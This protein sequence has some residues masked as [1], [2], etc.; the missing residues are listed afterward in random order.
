MSIWIANIQI[1]IIVALTT[2]FLLT[3][4]S[5]RPN[6]LHIAEPVRT[7]IDIN[8]DWLFI[9]GDRHQELKPKTQWQSI[10]LP[11]T[12]NAKDGL[13]GG[14]DY[15]RGYGTYQKHFQ[16]DPNLKGKRV[17]LHFD[18]ASIAARVYINDEFVG[19]HKGSYGAFRFDITDSI[20]WQG[21]NSL[22]VEVNNEEDHNVAPLSAD[23][24]FFGGLYRQA[25][26]IV[27][28]QV[29]VDMLDYASPGV[30][31]SQNSVDKNKA[32][33]EVSSTIINESETAETV[34]LQAIIK[35]ADG[36]VVARTVRNTTIPAGEDYKFSELLIVSQPHLWH[37]RKDPYLYRTYLQVSAA[38]Q[39]LDRVEQPIGLRF[40]HVDP[41]QGFFLNGE[42]YPLHGVNR[43]ADFPGM[44]TAITQEQHDI[45]MK[46][47][48]DIGAT[49]IRLGHQQRD[50]YVYSLTDK[51][52]LVVWAE[53]P[54]IN[55]INDDLAFS[56]NI[57]QQALELIKQNY[58]HS[59]IIFWGLFNEITLKKGPDPRPLVAQLNEMVKDLDPNRLTTAA[60]VAEG[61][62]DDPLVTLTDL[63]SFN[64]YYGWY[65]SG[66]SE[67]DTFL[68]ET[69][70]HAPDIRMGLSEFGAGASVKF[71]SDNPVMQDH[72]E[73]YQALFHEHY[74]NALKQRDFVW[75]KFAWVLADFAVDRRDEGD[76]PGRNDKGLVTFD[77]QIKKDAY[78]W[79]QANWSETPMI[80][81]SG[82][83]FNERRSDRADIKVYTNLKQVSLQ[84]NGEPIADTL[85][86]G[87]H[88]IVWDDVALSLGDNHLVVEGTDDQ[89][90][91]VRD[92]ILLTRVESND[93]RLNSNILGIDSDQGVIYNLPFGITAEKLP[94]YLSPA[95]GATMKLVGSQADKDIDATSRLEVVAQDG[96]TRQIY[97]FATGAVSLFKPTSA[98]AENISSFTI[99]PFTAPEATASKANDGLITREDSEFSDANMWLTLARQGP[100]WWKVDLNNVYYLDSIEQIW[101]QSLKHLLSSPVKYQIDVA[102]DF[103]QTFDVFSES[104]QMVVDG[105]DN[106][107]EGTV[108]HKLGVEGRFIKVTI[109]DTDLSVKVPV[110]GKQ[111]LYGAEEFTVVGGL[112]HS[113]EYTVDYPTRTVAISANV[114]EIKDIEK[115]LHPV[116][117]G[118][119][120]Y[121]SENG[122]ALSNTDKLSS[123][124]AI[125]ASSADGVLTE[126]YQVTRIH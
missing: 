100:Q 45:D 22:L 66:F 120:H 19:G 105:R 116:S 31:W 30:Y 21:D 81:I 28:N 82:R 11:H 115:F 106:Q 14:G 89:G 8:K 4:C 10:N 67:L 59:S 20:N 17:Y 90:Q 16:L 94:Q 41:E 5:S 55:R 79:Y 42:A 88:A 29:H 46:L 15:Y 107:Q 53:I 108:K 35:D 112:L 122:I 64:R 113:E 86:S 78:Y 24:T 2:M 74:W 103:Q 77:R 52:G 118:S 87:E 102:G 38:E 63:T 40:F 80:H 51:N 98:S 125:I 97:R 61:A 39:I 73:E 109:L 76:T 36:E 111:P 69:H 84:L 92:A 18:G 95:Q 49:G 104:Y 26:L 32:E 70:D 13:D 57:K 48:L 119:L 25:R 75:G 114:D 43:M 56:Q 62:L 1:S 34:T 33:I 96:N 117:G 37:G 93:T 99:G 3:S 121:L 65:H 23:F 44:G 124:D 101:P 123:L 72:T 54:L 12:W 27:T 60:V 47:M 6:E 91:T 126:R 7:L 9:K 110:M 71:H 68:D 85:T 83:R 58:N 50:D